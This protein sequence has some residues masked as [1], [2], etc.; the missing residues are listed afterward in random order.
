MQTGQ[1]IL[2]GHWRTDVTSWDSFVFVEITVN[3]NV[4]V[5]DGADKTVD[6][7]VI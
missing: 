5:D 1:G 7:I 6:T 3:Y 2:P 4:F